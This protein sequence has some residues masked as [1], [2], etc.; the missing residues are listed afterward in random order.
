MKPT[1]PSLQRIENIS[2]TIERLLR[3]L[4]FFLLLVMVLTVF[5]NVVAR[6][7][8]SISLNW[9]DEVSRG[10]FVWLVFI[11]IAVTMWPGGHIGLGNVISRLNRH[12]GYV[13]D[14]LAKVLILV[15]SIYLL[16]GGVKLVCLTM[17][18]MTEYLS[19]PAGYIY[20]IVPFG[21]TLM[22]LIGLRDL[23]RLIVTRGQNG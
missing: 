19:I 3:H 16:L 1:N 11:G 20:S 18:Q 8:F 13:A 7:F 12:V 22:F 6:Y 10:A 23:I 14:L 17:I 15:F 4:L 9:A 2:R 5:C 21:A